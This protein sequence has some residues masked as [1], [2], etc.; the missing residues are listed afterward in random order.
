MTTEMT[1]PSARTRTTHL[2]D[3]STGDNKPNIAIP[4]TTRHVTTVQKIT[5]KQLDSAAYA[6]E[7][8]D[9]KKGACFEA[10]NK[11]QISKPSLDFVLGLSP[12]LLVDYMK[13][14][15]NR[16]VSNTEKQF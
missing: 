1:V 9:V 2:F 11:K 8:E 14:R 16:T 5:S 12:N 15:K 3:E 7:S 13:G 6:N 4:L 10:A